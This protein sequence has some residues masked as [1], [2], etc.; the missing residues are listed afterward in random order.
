[1]SKNLESTQEKGDFDDNY[2]FRSAGAVRT[3]HQQVYEIQK[4][5]EQRMIE[6]FELSSTIKVLRIQSFDALSLQRSYNGIIGVENIAKHGISVVDRRRRSGGS[7]T[8]N[9]FVG[10]QIYVLQR[11]QRQRTHL[12]R[13]RGHSDRFYFFDQLTLSFFPS[14]YSHYS[15]LITIVGYVAL[16]PFF[17]H[18]NLRLIDCADSQ[19]PQGVLGRN[20][21]YFNFFV[22]FV[23]TK[24]TRLVSPTS[25]KARRHQNILRVFVLQCYA[26]R[27]SLDTHRTAYRTPPVSPFF[28]LPVTNEFAA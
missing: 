27:F 22:A 14:N 28:P 10:V 1:M 12:Y 15:L 20:F 4:V 19:N 11:W 6:F 5:D 3:L 24:H 2:L 25:T 21:H 13:F 26:I 8:S 16:E 17:P 7:T 18:K 9:I 23:E